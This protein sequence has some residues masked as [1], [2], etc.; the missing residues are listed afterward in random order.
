[1][2]KLKFYICFEKWE[3]DSSSLCCSHMGCARDAIYSSEADVK[4]QE[5]LPCITH[6]TE[7]QCQVMLLDS[8]FCQVWCG[9]A[10][11][12]HP[13]NLQSSKIQNASSN[14]WCWVWPPCVELLT[15]GCAQALQTGSSD[16]AD[17]G[18]LHPRTNVRS[19]A[20]TEVT[21]DS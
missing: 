3:G 21:P 17:R 18:C 16:A 13:S 10:L 19:A 7:L 5:V 15:A 8:P 2:E 1:M 20:I 9:A 4:L 12:Q 11:A 14:T 6:G